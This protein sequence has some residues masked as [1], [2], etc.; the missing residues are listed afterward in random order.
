MHLQFLLH[1]MIV[2]QFVL[3]YSH[4]CSQILYILDLHVDYACKDYT[5]EDCELDMSL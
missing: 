3:M 5:V 2:M 1:V 4:V